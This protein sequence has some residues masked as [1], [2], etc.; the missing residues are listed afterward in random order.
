M[1]GC[2]NDRR[3][4][5]NHQQILMNFKTQLGF[6]QSHR[7]FLKSNSNNICDWLRNHKYCQ[8]QEIYFTNYN[9]EAQFLNFKMSLLFLYKVI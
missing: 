9:M 8:R 2:V 5:C 1:Y 3:N 7:R 4:L 6:D